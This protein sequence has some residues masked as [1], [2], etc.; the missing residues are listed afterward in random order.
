MSVFMPPHSDVS[1]LGKEYLERRVASMQ[2]AVDREQ[3]RQEDGEASRREYWVGRLHEAKIALNN[4]TA[5]LER[6]GDHFVRRA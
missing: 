3:W 6:Q 4:L 1:A 5:G 2:E